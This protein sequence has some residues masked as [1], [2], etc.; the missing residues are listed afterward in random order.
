MYFSVHFTN[1]LT[2]FWA[3]MYIDQMKMTF[4]KHVKKHA[5]LT[6]S[7][8]INFPLCSSDYTLSYDRKISKY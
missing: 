5:L 7:W 4:I 8:L 6:H 1:Q 2:Y 3:M